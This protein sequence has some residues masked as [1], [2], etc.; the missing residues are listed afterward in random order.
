MGAVDCKKH[1]LHVAGPSCCDHVRMA[2]AHST[3]FI[4]YGI[5]RFD[6]FSD[7]TLVQ[8]YMLCTE[9]ATKYGLSV[10]EPISAE[11][12]ESEYL[13]PYV[14]PTCSQCFAEWSA[15]ARRTSADVPP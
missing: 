9:C 10:D 1:G 5:Y 12:W 11:V 2:V 13:F 15:T 4:P 6:V 8:P 14:C 7:G 3:A